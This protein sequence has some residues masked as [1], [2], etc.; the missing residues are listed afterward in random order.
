MKTD[1][2]LIIISVTSL[3][4]V[5]LFFL[6]SNILKK[7]IDQLV[8]SEKSKKNLNLLLENLKFLFI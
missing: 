5:I 8:L 1:V 6:V 7:K 4:G 2:A 3:F